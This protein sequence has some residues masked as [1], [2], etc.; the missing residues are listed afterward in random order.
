MDINDY[1]NNVLGEKCFFAQFLGGSSSV[2]GTDFHP[3]LH[4]EVYKKLSEISSEIVLWGLN[5][6]H[7]K[8]LM[9]TYSDHAS[10][11]NSKVILTDVDD[12]SERFSYILNL[13]MGVRG[14]IG[15]V[16]AGDKSNLL[17]EV[18]IHCDYIGFMS[19]LNQTISSHSRA[20]VNW[21][22][23]ESNNGRCVCMVGR[24]SGP[25]Y[26]DF[27]LPKDI[28]NSVIFKLYKTNEAAIR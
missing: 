22:I 24:F 6:S 25:K 27:F 10:I 9:T 18:L 11:R 28:M 13:A 5:E 4:G 7:K 8:D 14:S 2:T 12:F 3:I 20:S 21:A 19:S 26:I 16:V 1:I 17:I 23:D 15:F